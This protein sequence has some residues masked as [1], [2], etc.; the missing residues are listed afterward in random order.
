MRLL[1]YAF[2]H[3]DGWHLAV[4]LAGLLLF[5]RFAE[6][7]IGR[8]FT[9]LAFLAGAIGGGAAFLF[10]STREIG[11]AVGASGAVLALFG[12]ALA[13]LALDP[14]VRRTRPGRIELVFL[15]V[16]AAVQLLLDAFWEISAG[17][18]HAGG[19]VLGLLVGAIATFVQR[20]ASTRS[21]APSR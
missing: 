16:L 10:F 13:R 19:L 1:S 3:V 2:L 4:N 20:P 6:H 7:V 14:E 5:G 12:V 21:H 8:A 11:L 17:S 15:S 18:A 9:A